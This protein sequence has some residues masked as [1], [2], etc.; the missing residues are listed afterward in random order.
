MFYMGVSG[1]SVTS[2]GGA[3]VFSAGSGQGVSL[4]KADRKRKSVLSQSEILLK[5]RVGTFGP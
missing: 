1:A 5:R 4:M 3:S 2:S